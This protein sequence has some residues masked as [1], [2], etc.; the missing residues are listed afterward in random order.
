MSMDVYQI[1]YGG[2]VCNVAFPGHTHLL[3]SSSCFQEC[4]SVIRLR[5][6]LCCCLLFVMFYF[7]LLLFNCMRESEC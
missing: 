4:D 2:L 7:W 6:L 1:G 3:F 5:R